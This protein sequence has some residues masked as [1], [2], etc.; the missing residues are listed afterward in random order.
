MSKKLTQTF[1]WKIPM[2]L[3][4]TASTLLFLLTIAH[5]NT[6]YAAQCEYLQH[7]QWDTGF[8]SE[9]KITNDTADVIQGWTVSIHF[10]DN[11][12]IANVWNATLRGDNPYQAS[13][14]VY[15]GNINPNNTVQFGFNGTKGTANQDATAPTLG[16][17]CAAE[18]LNQTPIALPSVAQ[19]QGSIP[20]VASFDA[21]GSSDP[22]GDSLSYF[23]DF[24][25]GATSTQV[26][27][28]HT[29]AEVG[30]YV[31]SLIVNDGELDSAA[32]ELTITATEPSVV[33]SYGLDAGLSSLHF[34]STKKL[35]V[36]ETHT[37]TEIGG[38]ISTEGI[39]SLRINL[40]SVETGFSTRNQRVRDFLFETESFS[41]AEVELD[42]DLAG[43]INMPPGSV[44]EQNLA[45]HL[46]LHG[47]S[48]PINT[49][50]RITKLSSGSL[51]I[52][53]VQPIVLMAEDFALVDGIETLR[54]LAKLSVISYSVP[55]NFTLFYRPRDK[56]GEQ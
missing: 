29:Y 39:A 6:G 44:V 51:L 8:T 41:H 52:Q 12:S 26:A 31:V 14:F 35:N 38:E 11:T 15:N 55:V 23:W 24:G 5:L 34:L 54:T 10:S 49:K 32:Q 22:D 46:S 42:V 47:F 27:P 40:A 19:A 21:Q 17:V 16:G 13:N 1:Q 45:P 33:G 3:M 2:R 50:V 7:G 48:I 25:D 28:Q 36:V 20:F 30:N 18:T 37:F 53:N 43:L 4:K 9:V 56:E